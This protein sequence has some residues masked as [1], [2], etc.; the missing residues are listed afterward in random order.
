MATLVIEI[1]KKES[2]DA[3]KYTTFYY[4]SKAETMINEN[5]MDNAFEST[6][7]AIIWDIQKYLGKGSDWIIDSVVRH[8]INILKYNPLA[9]SSYIN[10]QK[11]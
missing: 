9:G 7:T 4:N 3:T 6:Y 10:C 8:T 1:K 11:I 5:D 2:D